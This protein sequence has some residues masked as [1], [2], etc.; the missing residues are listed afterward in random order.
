MDAAGPADSGGHLV[1]RAALT[2]KARHRGRVRRPTSMLWVSAAAV[3]FL[4]A[5]GR[6]DR[7]TELRIG[8][9]TTIEDSGLLQAIDSAFHELYPDQRLRVITGG[10]GEILELAR[11][12]DLDVTWTHDPIAEAEYVASGNG[13]ERFEVMWNEFVIAGPP[14][15]PA[16]IAGEQ[17]AAA[18]LVATLK[19][20]RSFVSRGD[21]SG[22][23]RRE[24]QLWRDVNVDADTLSR[25]PEYIVA[26]VGMG[27]A[28]RIASERGAYILTDLGTLTRLGPT[29]E[30]AV[31]VAGDARLVNRYAVIVRTGTSRQA[32]AEE[33]VRFL[34]QDEAGIIARFGA[35]EFGQPLFHQGPAPVR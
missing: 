23:H 31:H 9:T 2:F 30:L 20:G 17:D 22:T 12:G 35:A 15:D 13:T 6:S 33:F 21:E 8:A 25:K 16:N 14:L 34:R 19:A 7:K 5:C 24:I 18:A 1:R 26:G 3:L 29:L 32:A 11:R 10:T 28:L 27:D 4:A